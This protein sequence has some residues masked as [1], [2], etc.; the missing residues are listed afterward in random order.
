MN[1]GDGESNGKSEKANGVKL[2]SV[3]WAIPVGIRGGQGAAS[4]RWLA[5][6]GYNPGEPRVPAGQSDGGHWTSGGNN[7]A[8]REKLRVTQAQKLKSL[9][10]QYLEK[11]A[12]EDPGMGPQPGA[13]REYE[14][15]YAAAEEARKMAE[16]MKRRAYMLE[17][18]TE[19]NYRQLVL[20]QYGINNPELDKIA[21]YYAEKF[22][23][24]A[25]LNWLAKQRPAAAP[26]QKDW[27]DFIDG[28]GMMLMGGLAEEAEESSPEGT[29]GGA[30]KKSTFEQTT[31]AEDGTDD[32]G[33]TGN[34]EKAANEIPKI[35]GRR[36]VN[37][38]YAG[39]THPS[40]V[41]FTPQGFPDFSPHAIARVRVKGLT[42]NITKDTDLANVAA[43]LESTPKGYTWHHVEDGKTMELVPR[44]L[45]KSVGHTGGSAVIR[46]GGFDPK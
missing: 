14:R 29:V 34:T 31:E 30:P 32:D 9:A 38:K 45:H 40:G 46:N 3:P 13:G 33:G 19:D 20:E 41:K 36:P 16:E 43:G 39:K 28:V 15:R 42:G 22:H 25:T 2:G 18:G 11:A 35:R 10:Q 27:G 21:A 1:G 12:E 6:A 4:N 26:T 17:N 7:A 24:Q 8:D 44:D 5:N 23:D 37:S